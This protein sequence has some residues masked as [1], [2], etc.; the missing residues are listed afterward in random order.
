MTNCNFIGVGGLVVRNNTYLMVRH[1][2]GEYQ[3][4]WIIPGGRVQAGESL[5]DAVEREVW[6]ETGIKAESQGIIAVRSRC[7]DSDTTD[8]Y[9]VFLMNYLEGEPRA[10]GYE[11]D[12]VRFF[13][14][15]QLTGLENVIVLTRIIVCE[16]MGKTLRMLPLNTIHE[17]Y[18]VNCEEAQLFI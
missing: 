11:V 3:G 15:E 18:L 4:S 10:D 9:I 14:G 16:H 17:P 13:T 5:H 7:R 2:Y 12:D 1:A 8:C 6:E